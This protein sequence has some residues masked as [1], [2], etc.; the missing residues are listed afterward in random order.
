MD[1]LRPP[2]RPPLVGR[3]T[4]AHWI[5]FDCLAALLSLLVLLRAEHSLAEGPAW[6][7]VPSALLGAGAI[8]TRRLWPEPMLIRGALVLA[9]T[10]SLTVF[11]LQVV[12]LGFVLYSAVQGLPVRRSVWLLVGTL[13]LAAGGLTGHLSLRPG[14]VVFFSP[15]PVLGQLAVAALGWVLGLVVGQQRR[16][17]AAVRAQ[18]EQRAAAELAQAQR[19]LSDERL[20]IARELHDVLAH[21]MSLIAVQAGVANHVAAERPDEA[22]RALTAIE[23]TSRG[24][25]RELRALLGVLRTPDGHGAEHA[26]T[27]GLADLDALLARTAD[28]GV[29]VELTETGERPPSLPTG[30][31]L[32]LFRV[33]QESLTNVVKHAGA[34]RCAVA[35]AFTDRTVTLAITDPGPAT[36]TAPAATTRDTGPTGH[37]IA[38]MRE[39]VTMYGGELHAGPLPTGGFRVTAG[40]PL[41]APEVSP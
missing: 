22:R 1:P 17:S 4:N 39:R 6:T 9:L 12:A 15:A 37:G 14:R 29:R 31:Q 38:G 25:L 10:T 21:S 23:D 13:V 28:A 24:A 27:P 19:A 8:A 34:D 3:L 30:L 32:A 26:P 2:L 11:P 40:L 41:A 33:V 16:Y 18:A 35:L 20:R 36:P 5:G 7:V